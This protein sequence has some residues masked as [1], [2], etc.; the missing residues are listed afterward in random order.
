MIGGG[1]HIMDLLSRPEGAG[2]V[3]ET[4]I[5]LNQRKRGFSF[6]G[7]HF[8][9]LSARLKRGANHREGKEKSRGL[10]TT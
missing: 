10:R 9:K 1:N 4:Q 5:K 6:G 7:S 3:W 2:I 8:G